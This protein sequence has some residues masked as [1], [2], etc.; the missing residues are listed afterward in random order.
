VA[1]F[2]IELLLLVNIRESVLN[3]KRGPSFV[4]CQVVLME[5]LVGSEVGSLLFTAADV[6][7]LQ[8]IYRLWLNRFG[9]LDAS[10]N[11]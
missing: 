3:G 9:P 6:G 8:F 10:Y 2:R 4:K 7:D 11:G 1:S 5:L